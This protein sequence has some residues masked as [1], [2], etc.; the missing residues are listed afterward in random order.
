MVTEIRLTLY[1]LRVLELFS[2]NRKKGLSGSEVATKTNLTNGTLYPL[3]SRLE[4]AGLLSGV[5]EIG[6]PRAMKRPRKRFYKIT[7]VGI[8]RLQFEQFFTA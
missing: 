3:L 4:T 5:W 1:G 7:E 8:K 2:R 6:D